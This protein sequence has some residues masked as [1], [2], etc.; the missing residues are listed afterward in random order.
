MNKH[1]HLQARVLKFLYAY[2]AIVILACIGGGFVLTFGQGGSMAAASPLILVAASEMLRIP[3]SSFAVQLDTAGRVLAFIVLAAIAVVS[4]DALTIIFEQFLDNRAAAVLSAQRAYDLARDQLDDQKRVVANARALVDQAKS[5]LASVDASIATK[6]AAAPAQPIPSGKTCGKGNWT[7]SADRMARSDFAK[8]QVAHLAAL[9]Q[10]RTER[11]DAQTALEQETRA[12][13][14]LST[15]QLERSLVSA[16]HTLEDTKLL[17]PMHRLFASILG[18]RVTELTTDQFEQVK[19][20]GVIGL[21][22]AFA[23]IS[24]FV[25][26]LAHQ[27]ERGTAQESK[28]SRALRA[29]V[30]RKRR[31]L[32]R[33]VKETIPAGTKIKYVYVPVPSGFDEGLLKR[34]GFRKDKV[35]AYSELN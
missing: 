28:L 2:E 17:S 32:I 4:F 19:R 30:A 7:C 35:R 13:A 16:R 1:A 12:M 5:N 34:T 33:V 27:P 25:S 10:L 23:T 6:E 21:S 3:I 14:A 18:V 31:P 20:I 11:K 24:M 8:A 22:G 26:V 9:K 29:Y 15:E